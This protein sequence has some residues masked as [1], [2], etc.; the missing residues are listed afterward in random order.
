MTLTH[1][2][3]PFA[4][5]HGRSPLRLLAVGIM[6]LAAA[7]S[8]P[9]RA[10]APERPY[11][12]WR[13]ITTA[14]FVIHYPPSLDDW[15]RDVASRLDPVDSAVRRIVG[16]AP[17]GRT[18]V[19]VDDPYA[20]SNGF[21]IPE[22][23][24]PTITFWA[25]PPSPRLDIG[26]V[27]TWTEMLAVHEFTHVAHLSR[28]S[29]NPFSRRLWSVLPVDAGPIALRAPRWV[30]EGYATYVEGRLTGTGRPNNAWR[31]AV[32][33][34]WAIEGQLPTYAELSEWGAYR[35][36]SF[37]YL[38]GSAYFEWLVGRGGDSSLVHLWRRL[39]A[40]RQR[41]FVEA[42]AGVY[43]ESPAYLYGRFAAELTASA[44]TARRMLAEAGLDTGALVQHLAWETGD[45]A[46]SPNGGHIAIVLRS[47]DR[48]SR[49]VVWR[50]A[51]EPDTTAARRDSALLRRDPEDVPPVRPYPPPKHALSTLRS[52]GGYAFDEP[53]FLSDGRRL[54]V[55]RFTPQG[56]GT[57][58]PDLY[59]W[60]TR[61]DHVHRIT[62]GAGI[63]NAD[64][65]PDGRA[66]IAER[67]GGG[68]CDIVRVDLETGAI[69]PVAMG[70][71]ASSYY[72]PR[73]S[74]DGSEAVASV[75]RA[76]RWRLVR[77]ELASGAQ[78]LVDPDDGA[79]RFDAAWLS[80][81]E[82]VTTSDRGGIA[83]LERID[84]ATGTP[85]ALTRVTGAAVAA[86]PDRRTRG[87]WFLS[88][89]SRGFDLRR[90]DT[91]RTA[92]GV[93]T[94]PAALGPVARK[95]LDSAPPI[96]RIAVPPA[97]DYGLGV[98]SA[99][100]LPGGS[101]G[102]DGGNV[103][104]AIVQSDVVGRLE[105]L[106]QG[107]LGDASAWQGG[108]LAL[109]WRGWRPVARVELFDARQTPSRSRAV[110]A[111]PTGLDVR[112]R[113]AGGVLELEQ[114]VGSWAH[115]E[116]VG[117][118]WSTLASDSSARGERRIAFARLGLAARHVGDGW[119]AAAAIAL[120]GAAGRT[121]ERDFG[122]GT[123][124]LSVATGGPDG[125]P[126]VGHVT[127]GRASAGTPA[128]EEFAVGGLPPPMLDGELLAQ[129][130]VEP[131]L[132]TAVAVGRELISWRAS[133]PLGVLAP[134]YAGA[135]AGPVAGP[136]QWHRVYGIE[137]TFASGY[138]P[139]VRLP[140]VR[141]AV[142]VARSLDAPFARTTRGY[143]MLV[144]RP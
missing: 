130:V 63:A 103:A 89:H 102:P 72:R 9:A 113:G 30:D 71:I 70:S 64:P 47:Y 78:H 52:R 95:Q 83:N 81:T 3:L 67:C 134:Y 122:R 98:R 11:L 105:L 41:G 39:S 2:R 104:L 27:R 45:P 112:L 121:D 125:M 51:D 79:N 144:W 88:L 73:V 110:A 35:G 124:T 56:D 123:A 34:Q 28:P 108:S 25:T 132:P 13:T 5:A 93:V 106:A 97:H 38:A 111:A 139:I 90:L 29:R 75:Q 33:R 23:G 137:A 31:A 94:L 61:D 15:A 142:G 57:V 68:H 86:A 59:L 126:F 16:Y 46:L 107:A 6:L 48:P 42:F 91:L 114:D 82:L 143:A 32:L 77:I 21:A 58:R 17:P 87:V 22:I 55:V 80:R 24:R 50:T 118:A 44:L 92:P 100:W 26:D 141:T 99:R 138:A 127:Y 74:P 69:L 54:L 101:L 62:W 4:L 96:P 129:R 40:R 49:V 65:L 115:E 76:G 14:H 133:L 37:A 7:R 1:R 85:T 20:L 131:A 128:F 12:H 8:A 119:H 117:G 136:R 18:E 10:Q 140:G 135:S 120:H 116:A 19:V 109:A 60:D 66:A 36:G 43:G 84:L 53:R